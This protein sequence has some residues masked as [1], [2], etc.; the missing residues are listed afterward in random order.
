M[1]ELRLQYHRDTGI[2][3]DDR[4]GNASVE[5]TEYIEYLEREI[6]FAIKKLNEINDQINIIR[7][8]G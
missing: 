2:R 7:V 1:N 3:I 6:E 4:I 8:F 5:V